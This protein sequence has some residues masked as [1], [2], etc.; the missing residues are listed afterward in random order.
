VLANL[1][2]GRNVFPEF[3]QEDCTPSKLSEALLPL[4]KDSQ[5]RRAQKAALAEI[6]TK[7]ALAG[8]SPSEKA[9]EIVFALMNSG[10]TE[11]PSFNENP[12]K[13]AAAAE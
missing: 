7:L 5:E 3:I 2:L 13:L 8:G 9:A 1:V 10:T 11:R 6:R 12:Q 4:L